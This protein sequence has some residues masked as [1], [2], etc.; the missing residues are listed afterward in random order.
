MEQ[1]KQPSF[2]PSMKSSGTLPEAHQVR[3]TDTGPP[4]PCRVV[5][6]PLTKAEE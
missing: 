6:I 5:Q 1:D 3:A 2:H 4:H